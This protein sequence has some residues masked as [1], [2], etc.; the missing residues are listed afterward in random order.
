[1]KGPFTTNGYRKIKNKR[2]EN[3]ILSSTNLK[4]SWGISLILI[5]RE[6]KRKK[7]KQGYFKVLKETPES[8][9]SINIFALY[10]IS[11]KYANNN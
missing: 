10:S 11:S 8:K 3:Y 2:A 1:M 7:G 5:K 9:I 6:I 4:E